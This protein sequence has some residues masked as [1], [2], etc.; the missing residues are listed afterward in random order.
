MPTQ[1]KQECRA[2][3]IRCDILP[4]KGQFLLPDRFVPTDEILAPWKRRWTG[5]QNRRVGL[6]PHRSVR[7]HSVGKLAEN[8]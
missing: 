1:L 8:W 2:L 7:A 5:D 4:F 3:L 6:I